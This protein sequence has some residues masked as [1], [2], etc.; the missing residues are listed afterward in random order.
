MLMISGLL[1]KRKKKCLKAIFK[2]LKDFERFAGLKV[3]Y[4]KTELLRIGSVR[5][6]DASFYSDFKLKWSEGSIKILGLLCVNDL[7][8]MA[9]INY[10]ALFKKMETITQLWSKRNLTL[11][12]KIVVVNTLI[13]P[14]FTYNI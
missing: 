12:G 9:E 4:N 3:N 11:L 7:D 1:Q 5:D 8:E 13:M 14:L 10:A 6:G 2:I